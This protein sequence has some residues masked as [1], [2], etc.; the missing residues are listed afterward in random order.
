MKYLILAI[1]VLAAICSS[2]AKTV[3]ECANEAKRCKAFIAPMFR[4]GNSKEGLIRSIR[5]T[6]L[7]D[8]C[9]AANAFLD[10]NTRILDDSECNIHEAVSKYQPL[11]IRLTKVVTFMCVK[12]KDAIERAIPCVTT[13]QFLGKIARCKRTHPCNS[14]ESWNCAKLA[15]AQTCDS[16][17]SEWFNGY[18]SVFKQ[19]HPGCGEDSLVKQFYGAMR[20]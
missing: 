19:N 16:A 14:E 15:V 1:V 2:Q 7:N 12:E 8:I 6:P 11:K 18:I 3:A 9:S 5:T 4:N 17:T 13:R 20:S 10:C